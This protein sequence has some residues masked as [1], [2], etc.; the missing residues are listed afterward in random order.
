MMLAFLC[1]RR[2]QRLKTQHVSLEDAAQYGDV[3]RNLARMWNSVSPMHPMPTF[4]QRLD[5]PEDPFAVLNQ[6]CE[7]VQHTPDSRA[8]VRKLF[9]EY[10]IHPDAALAYIKCCKA[11]PASQTAQAARAASASTGS[12][13]VQKPT[14]NW[15]DMSQSIGGA[16]FGG[17]TGLG[18]YALLDRAFS[19]P[20]PQ[21]DPM[22]L[23]AL[24]GG[25][26]LA[27]GAL[28]AYVLAQQ[29]PS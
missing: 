5:V 26:G 8:I 28:L 17:L 4:A 12:T 22:V 29:R 25:S 7:I 1:M 2:M 16:A 15:L 14:T 13:T 23:A 21:L 3:L 19:K 20:K 6:I 27:F 11:P 24:A 18:T 10:G 9:T